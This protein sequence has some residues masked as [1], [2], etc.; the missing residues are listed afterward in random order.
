MIDYTKLSE[1]QLRVYLKSALLAIGIPANLYDKSII[2]NVYSEIN[3]EYKYDED[4]ITS[5]NVI[6]S[7]RT[8]MGLSVLDYVSLIDR[9]DEEVLVISDYEKF[10]E[11]QKLVI[12]STDKR[13]LNLLISNVGVV[14]S[15]WSHPYIRY[16]KVI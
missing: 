16:A 12:V 11:G 10:K 4:P 6:L 8:G 9:L 15:D 7:G 5:I 3:P 14:Q 2:D 13:K 1:K